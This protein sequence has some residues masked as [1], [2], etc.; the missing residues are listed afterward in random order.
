MGLAHVALLNGKTSSNVEVGQSLGYISIIFYIVI[1]VAVVFFSFYFFVVLAL[2]HYT[3][4]YLSEAT[5]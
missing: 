2:E 4:T 5:Q 3:S 1:S